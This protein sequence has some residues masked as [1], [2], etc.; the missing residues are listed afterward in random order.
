M[1]FSCGA[2]IHFE[3]TWPI[4][5]YVLK[6]TIALGAVSTSV[7]FAVRYVKDGECDDTGEQVGPSTPIGVVG[8][9]F[10]GLC[11]WLPFFPL[12]CLGS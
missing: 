10:I 5:L 11:L 7:Y 6:G 4:L 8:W 1:P 3:M 2:V 9:A 12:L